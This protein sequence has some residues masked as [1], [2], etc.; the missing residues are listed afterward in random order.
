[1]FIFSCSSFFQYTAEI[2]LLE[3]VVNCLPNQGGQKDFQ[4]KENSLFLLGKCSWKNYMNTGIALC[5]W[6]L[7]HFHNLT[8]Q[9]FI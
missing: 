4:L 3:S 7:A 9:Y 8:E 1:M 2:T 5:P 6:S